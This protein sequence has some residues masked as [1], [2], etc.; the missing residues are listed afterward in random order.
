METTHTN[1]TKTI[2]DKHAKEI[3]DMESK[4]AQAFKTL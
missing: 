1:D 4:H 2:V 3:N